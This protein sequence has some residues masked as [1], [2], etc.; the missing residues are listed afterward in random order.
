MKN[1]ETK[2]PNTD[3]INAAPELLEALKANVDAFDEWRMAEG[4]DSP[5]PEY[6]TRARAAIARI[7]AKSDRVAVRKTISPLQHLAITYSSR[8]PDKLPSWSKEGETQDKA[9]KRHA[10]E[11]K[12][13]IAFR[14]K[15]IFP[16]FHPDTTTVKEY[17]NAYYRINFASLLTPYNPDELSDN[18]QCLFDDGII[19]ETIEDDPVSATVIEIPS[20]LR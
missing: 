7:D 10:A 16:R 9:L 13:N 1:Q 14:E 6:I 4:D 5:D 17:I 20:F 2:T 15:R 12:R 8:K 11:L 19:M 18:P 3:L